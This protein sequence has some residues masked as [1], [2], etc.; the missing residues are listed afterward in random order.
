MAEKTINDDHLDFK[1]G[2]ENI[3]YLESLWKEL[4]GKDSV[5]VDKSRADAGIWKVTFASKDLCVKLIKTRRK[6]PL[7][8]RFN[9][10]KMSISIGNKAVTTDY[11]GFTSTLNSL[12]AILG[13]DLAEERKRLEEEQARIQKDIRERKKRIVL[14]TRARLLDLL[15]SQLIA[16]G[17]KR[18]RAWISSVYYDNGANL[19]FARLKIREEEGIFFKQDIGGYLKSSFLEEN[20]IRILRVTL[21]EY[22]I[23]IPKDA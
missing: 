20:F 14:E 2:P 3:E 1:D 7:V 4:L 6:N 13:Q 19:F 9:Q 22:G 8:V 12:I 17:V 15:N 11:L 18:K 10:G 21:A 23:K 5:S 16:W